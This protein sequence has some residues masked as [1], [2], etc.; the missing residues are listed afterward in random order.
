MDC[1]VQGRPGVSVDGRAGP[2][3]EIE[4]GARA[5]HQRFGVD[6]EVGPVDD[7]KTRIEAHGPPRPQTTANAHGFHA[8]GMVLDRRERGGFIVLPALLNRQV[9]VTAGSTTPAGRRAFPVST[10]TAGAPMSKG[11][12]MKSLE[13][14]RCCDRS[15]S[16]ST[17]PESPA[18]APVT[19]GALSVRL[20]KVSSNPDE[21]ALS[22]ALAS[23]SA[24]VPP[25]RRA[26][27][28]A[29]ADIPAAFCSIPYPPR[30]RSRPRAAAGSGRSGSRYC[31]ASRRTAPPRSRVTV[32][33]T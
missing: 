6:P 9:P 12:A 7:V 11:S 21:V 26:T 8:R 32:P 17:A 25:A 2:I 16:T 24:C 3:G 31:R 5:A 27:P 23:R 33:A 29:W 13:K 18:W 20:P 1:A 22:R 30:A 14:W 15:T 4:G 28:T 10:A 19:G